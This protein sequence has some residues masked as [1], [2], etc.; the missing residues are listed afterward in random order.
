MATWQGSTF[1]H[2]LR[3][4]YASRCTTCWCIECINSTERQR[5]GE[6][7]YNSTPN[8]SQKTDWRCWKWSDPKPF[9]PFIK[10]TC[11]HPSR[12]TL[13]H[14]IAWNQI[15]YSQD[16]FRVPYMACAHHVW[17]LSG[18]CLSLS[19]SVIFSICVNWTRTDV[20]VLTC[21]HLY[22]PVGFGLNNQQ[23]QK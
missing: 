10:R 23:Q 15:G 11:L 4:F 3:W 16:K 6:H 14:C 8:P 17:W 7:N 1:A 20:F 19:L 18:S 22:G 21:Y 12:M 9:L 13:P 2:T 5:E